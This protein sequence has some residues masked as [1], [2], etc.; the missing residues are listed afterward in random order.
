MPILDFTMMATEQSIFTT[1][2]VG[3]VLVLAREQAGNVSSGTHMQLLRNPGQSHGRLAAQPDSNP[4]FI[5]MPLASGL[6]VPF[7]PTQ[8]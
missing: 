8:L 4:H 6:Q 3:F 2:S 7:R 1:P 5:R